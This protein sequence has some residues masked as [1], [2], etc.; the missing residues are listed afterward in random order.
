[1]WWGKLLMYFVSNAEF[2]DNLLSP[3]ATYITG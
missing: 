1:M 3:V 2:Q